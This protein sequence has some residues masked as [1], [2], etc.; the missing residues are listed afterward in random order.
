[1][2]ITAAERS[3][4]IKLAA[5]LPEGS[6]ERRAILKGLKQAWD[7]KPWVKLTQ[8]VSLPGGWAVAGRGS[9]PEDV[10]HSDRDR[11]ISFAFSPSLSDYRWPFRKPTLWLGSESWE[12][13]QV[14]APVAATWTGNPAKDLPVWEKA[15]G[16]AI[17]AFKKGGLDRE[18]VIAA[19][20]GAKWQSY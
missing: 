3:S 18:A 10:F 16:A 2:K 17:Q 14:V 11:S 4:L 5:S 19:L 6:E 12:D 20:P 8:G 13:G 9:Q 1:M 7:W 15:V